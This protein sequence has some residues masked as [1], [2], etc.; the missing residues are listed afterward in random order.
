MKK[1]LI[2]LTFALLLSSCSSLV[3][4]SSAETTDNSD[5]LSET[6]V[7]ASDN[8]SQC[9]TSDTCDCRVFE[10]TIP[11][12]S[13]TVSEVSEEFD[14][15]SKLNEPA[16]YEDF[17]LVKGENN[18]IIYS[19]DYKYSDTD[20]SALTQ[21]GQYYRFNIGDAGNDAILQRLKDHFLT[22]GIDMDNIKDDDYFNFNCTVN[23]K[24]QLFTYSDME[25]VYEIKYRPSGTDE[26]KSDTFT[27]TPIV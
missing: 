21:Y 12:E 20:T 5:T 24:N 18:S 17:D 22:L 1:T 10:T 15:H 19:E 9:E 2:I 4:N 27:D 3:D 26:I 23:S 6:T 13:E 7:R 11:L 16:Q 8:N 25:M 14:V